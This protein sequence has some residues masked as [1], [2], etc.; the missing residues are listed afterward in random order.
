MNISVILCTYN[1]CEDL[2]E[3]LKSFCALDIPPGVKWELLIV[4]NNSSDQTLSVC[5]QFAGSLPMR[6]VFEPKQGKSCALNRGIQEAKANLLAFTDDDVDV[7]SKWVSELWQTSESRHEDMFFGGKI[8]PKWEHPPPKWLAD[9]SDG[10]LRALSVCYDRGP[11]P[12][13]LRTDEPLFY[14]ANMAIRRSAFANGLRFREDLGPNGRGAVRGEEIELLTNLLQQGHKGFYVP[15][16]I[17]SHRNPRER[18]TERYL[19]QWYKGAGMEAVVRGHYENTM[20]KW[21]GAPGYLWRQLFLHARIF[22]IT[23]YTC[24]PF[25]W[26]PAEIAMAK[27]WGAICEFSHRNA[28]GERSGE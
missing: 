15:T 20:R 14:G 8:V 6:Y 17:V 1:R 21:L 11:E 2:R 10:M 4:D 24:P 19:R 7:D 23:R 26:L 27:A 9:H 5:Q 16:A 22:A 12:H 13:S 25:V 28:R 18:M 3:T